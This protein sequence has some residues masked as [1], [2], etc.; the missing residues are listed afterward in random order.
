LLLVLAG[1][2]LCTAAAVL[3]LPSEKSATAVATA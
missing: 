2:A 1:I 3:W